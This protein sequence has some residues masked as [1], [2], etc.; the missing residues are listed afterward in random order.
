MEHI[1]PVPVPEA[2]HPAWCAPDAHDYVGDMD[3]WHRS[4][5]RVL[6]TV[7]TRE[8][9]RNDVEVSVEQYVEHR[10]GTDMWEP[11]PPTVLLH[12]TRDA[13]ADLSPFEA[14]QLAQMLLAAADVADGLAVTW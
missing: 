12:P 5:V 9:D 11:K 13:G 4:Q 8:N 1:Q 6:E 3:S 10:V 7:D 2:L 14:R